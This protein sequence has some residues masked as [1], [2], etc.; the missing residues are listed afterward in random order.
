MFLTLTTNADSWLPPKP[1]ASASPDGRIVVRIIPGDFETKK[2]PTAT[3]FELSE[4]SLSYKKVREFPLINNMA[5]LTACISNSGE[6]STFDNWGGTGKKH[7]AVCYTL[8]GE[9]KIEFTLDQ[10][11]PAEAVATLKMKH[12]SMSSIDWREG[13]PMINGSYIIVY[14][15]LGG[16]VCITGKIASRT[17]AKNKQSQPEHAPYRLLRRAQGDA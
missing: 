14:D 5:P 17:P 8:T 2:K 3:I 13:Q 1:I 12:Q 7:V 9:V 10:L 6:L 11:F 15:V 4:D 16:Y